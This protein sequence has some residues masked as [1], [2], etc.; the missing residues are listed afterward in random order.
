MI[1]LTF[2]VR[3]ARAELKKAVEGDKSKAQ[4]VPLTI[5]DETVVLVTPEILKSQGS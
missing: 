4:I 1:L 2:V 3:K 5:D